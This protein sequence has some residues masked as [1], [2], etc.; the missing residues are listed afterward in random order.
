MKVLLLT[1][2]VYP[3]V[4]GGIQ[5]HSYYL[6]K[7]FTKNNIK[8]HLVH[9]IYTGEPPQNEAE[10]LKMTKDSASNITFS[11]FKFPKTNK[12]PGHYVKEY[13]IYSSQIYEEL[14]FDL[15]KFD[16]IYAQGFTAWTFIKKAKK[17]LINK[18]IFVNLHGYEMFQDAP[19]VKAK[20][21]QQL[22]RKTAKW[23]SVN[24]DHVFSFGGKIT[25][26]LNNIGVSKSRIIELPIG[27]E[28][29]WLGTYKKTTSNLRKFI[30]VG[31][32][33][34]R[35]GIEELTTVLKQLIKGDLPPFE[36][37][38]IG[39]IPQNKRIKD[40]RIIYHGEI[41]DEKKIRRMILQTEVLVC[42]SHAEGMPTVILEA[43]ATG[44]AII[45]NNVGSVMKQVNGNGWLL[46]KPYA[47]SLKNAL[48]EAVLMDPK[49]LDKLRQHS[50]KRIQKDFLWDILIKK[51]IRE[52][53]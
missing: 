14:K 7:Y 24:A 16:L 17:G 21:E 50:V 18:P 49:E 33:E 5:K 22:F 46:E 25:R 38:F 11:S 13:K 4:M 47:H 1:D 28:A 52:L 19:T 32:F 27:I 41:N 12:L 10:V 45:A 8:V 3:F 36:F 6:A 15:K 23:I 35:K 53:K 40:K 20:L 2:G 48:T 44:N 37:H 43:M 51:L 30:F 31:R 29:S 39:P 34:R 9:C 42:P 26:I